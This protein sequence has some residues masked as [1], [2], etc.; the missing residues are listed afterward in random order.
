M[1][2][3][4]SKS[5]TMKLDVKTTPYFAAYPLKALSLSSQASTNNDSKS[6]IQTKKMTRRLRVSPM[7]NP[8]FE[9]KI[10]INKIKL[11]VHIHPVD[12][13]WFNNYE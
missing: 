4:P 3:G 9:K 13:N 6:N 12:G 8:Y 1:K 11:P 10:S 2:T 5:V 7:I